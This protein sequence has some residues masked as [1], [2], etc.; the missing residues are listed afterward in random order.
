MSKSQFQNRI[1]ELDKLIDTTDDLLELKAIYNELEDIHFKIGVILQELD[2]KY[3][4]I[5]I[6]QQ[7][8]Q[9]TRIN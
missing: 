1:D 4:S 6:A 5:M 2:Q 9:I 3:K 7:I 8:K